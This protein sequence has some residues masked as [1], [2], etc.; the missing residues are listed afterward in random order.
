MSSQSVYGFLAC[1]ASSLLW[2]F[3][4]QSHILLQMRQSDSPHLPLSTAAELDQ[5]IAPLQEV[6]RIPKTE[7]EPDVARAQ[8]LAC[9]YGPWLWQLAFS[10][11]LL[12]SLKFWYSPLSPPCAVCFGEVCRANTRG[13]VPACCLCSP[14]ALPSFNLCP[15][16]HDLATLAAQD[17][18]PGLQLIPTWPSLDLNAEAHRL[19]VMETRYS[20]TEGFFALIC[21]MLPFNMTSHR[22]GQVPW[23]FLPDGRL[24][25][26]ARAR[27][28]CSFDGITVGTTISMPMHYRMNDRPRHIELLCHYPYHPML[29]P[30]HHPNFT[31]SL[32]YNYRG[33]LAAEE[34]TAEMAADATAILH[35]CPM[36][37]P[38]VAFS[39]CC[40]ALRGKEIIP[41][42]VDFIRYHNLL[43]VSRFMM[44]DDTGVLF[45]ALSRLVDEGSWIIIVHQH[46]FPSRF[47]IGW[48]MS[49]VKFVAPVTGIPLDGF[50]TPTRMR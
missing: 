32:Q 23:Q 12:A 20:Y 26:A 9:R 5:L 44:H 41:Q 42:V 11:L 45:Q 15:L 30:S 13:D 35:V 49:S 48:K 39:W 31:I 28:S 8:Q 1:P 40:K 34:P 19:I 27:I 21:I 29:P 14:V 2:H 3:D 37:R 4:E 47:T 7:T 25:A 46:S 43:G 16:P 10:T 24:A 22:L 18:S 17:D 33:R 6:S 50:C 36:I 38:V